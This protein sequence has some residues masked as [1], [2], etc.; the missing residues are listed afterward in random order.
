MFVNRKQATD[1][2]SSGD[3]LCRPAGDTALPD[4][5]KPFRDESFQGEEEAQPAPSSKEKPS[6]E[7]EVVEV[8]KTPTLDKLDAMISGKTLGTLSARIKERQGFQGVADILGKNMAVDVLGMSAPTHGI[9]PKT[10]DKLIVERRLRRVKSRVALKSA[11]KLDYLMTNCLTEEKIDQVDS[12]LELA[13]LGKD[14]AVITQ[15]MGPKD[16]QQEG[17]VHFHVYRPELKQV[18]NYETITVGVAE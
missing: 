15:S 10:G 4:N 14:L 7:K 2:L 12:P 18:N 5:E 17:G 8:L 11:R 1:R 6:S 9:D 16:E 13:R 3:N